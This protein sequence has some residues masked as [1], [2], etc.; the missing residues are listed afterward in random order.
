MSD[1]IL[2]AETAASESDLLLLNPKAL[3]CYEDSTDP[4]G[5]FEHEV[6]INNDAYDLIRATKT[7]TSPT[8]WQ[9]KKSIW[10]GRYIELMSNLEK[11]DVA[12]WA[13]VVN[14]EHTAHLKKDGNCFGMAQ[15]T[16]TWVDMGQSMS[17]NMPYFLKSKLRFSEEE[18]FKNPG[19]KYKELVDSEEIDTYAVMDFFM[20]THF[21]A[22]WV[23]SESSANYAM[24]GSDWHSHGINVSH[25]AYRPENGIQQWVSK[26]SD[27]LPVILHSNT[28]QLESKTM[29]NCLRYYKRTEGMIEHTI[30]QPKI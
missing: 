20:E 23:S 10:E 12:E 5:Y 25:I 19:L 16:N 28:A 1:E 6:Y 9:G 21:S 24:Y 4:I 22:T 15:G 2:L 13:F 18:A 30:I 7:A 17:S 8:H 11:L 14:K 29:R 26:P 27:S 3:T